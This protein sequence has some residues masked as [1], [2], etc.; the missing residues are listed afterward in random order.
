MNGMKFSWN[1]F[2]EFRRLFMC[3][4]L[5]PREFNC[6]IDVIFECKF[7]HAD[8]HQGHGELQKFCVFS[9]REVLYITSFLY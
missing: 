9:P 6:S 2:L 5:D 4:S 8:I 1:E 3:L 7:T